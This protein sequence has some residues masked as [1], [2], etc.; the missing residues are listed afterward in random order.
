MTPKE[1]IIQLEIIATNLTGQ[2]ASEVS[3]KRA[4]FFKRKI[5]ALDM[6]IEALKG[7]ALCGAT[8]L[9]CIKCNPGPCD[10]RCGGAK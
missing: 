4:E 7:N 5:D 3:D 8:G 10:H 2:Y 9:P 1:A 6:A